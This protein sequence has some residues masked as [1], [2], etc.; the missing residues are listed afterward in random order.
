MSESS[1]LEP[2]Q[3]PVLAMDDLFP[4]GEMTTMTKTKREREEFGD[5]RRTRRMA[6]ERMREWGTVTP[7][8]PV[9][10]LLKQWTA[11]PPP[12]I[13]PRGALIVATFSAKDPAG[14]RLPQKIPHD[15]AEKTHPGPRV[16]NC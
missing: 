4:V 14:K 6:K 5:H 13:T 15:E 12:H 10:P 7:A 9:F 16:E 8:V 3:A 2:I 1:T 11:E